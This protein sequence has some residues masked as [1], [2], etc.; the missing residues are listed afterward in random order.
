MLRCS[1]QIALTLRVGLRLHEG[2]VEVALVV[3]VV[4][5]PLPPG[6]ARVDERLV[7]GDVL[8]LD[9]P[10]LLVELAGDRLHVGG[11]DV[12]VEVHGLLLGRHDG[13]RVQLGE[14]VAP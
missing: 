9:Q 12:H 5:Q 11:A 2:V 6:L 3:L 7:V 4:D 13:Q 8:L 10:D 14:R 1:S